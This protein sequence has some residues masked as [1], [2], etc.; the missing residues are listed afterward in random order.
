MSSTNKTENIIL[1]QFIGS[2]KPTFLGDYNSDM[3]KIDTAFNNLKN[4]TDTNTSNIITTSAT[5][6]SALSNSETANEKANEAK[7]TATSAIS[8]A[9]NNLEE[10]NKLKSLFNISNFD[11]LQFSNSNITNATLNNVNFENSLTLAYNEDKTI[12]KLYGTIVVNVSNRQTSILFKINSNLRPTKEFSINTAGFFGSINTIAPA[13][14][15][16]KTNGDIE[17]STFAFEN[18]LMRLM[19]YP[20]LYFFKD[21]GDTLP[22]TI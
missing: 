10:I 2:D 8:T 22:T 9:T 19:M 12:G 20:C 6:N 3:V 17:I 18:G 1:S 21:F 15:T 4:S 16:F 7:I 5:A 14:I 11:K 13:N